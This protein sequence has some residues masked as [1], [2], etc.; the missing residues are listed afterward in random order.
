[1]EEKI[2]PLY[3]CAMIQLAAGLPPIEFSF[4]S[5]LAIGAPFSA[6]SEL[7][8]VLAMAGDPCNFSTFIVLLMAATDEMRRGK[9]W[10]SLLIGE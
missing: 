2:L 8:P 7:F 3:S 9:I 4:R 6:I 1:M 5:I 10:Y